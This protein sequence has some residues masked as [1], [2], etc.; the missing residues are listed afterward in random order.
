M[1]KKAS[2]KGGNFQD[3]LRRGITDKIIEALKNGCP[4]W[5][6][7]WATDPNCGLPCNIASKRRYSGI[8]PLILE[9]VALEKGYNAR[10]WGTYKQFSALEGQVRKGEKST[11]VVFYKVLEV[12][13]KAADGNP[14]K[15]KIFFLRTYNVFNL[16]Q[17]DG[18]KLDKYRVKEEPVD[19]PIS[20]SDCLLD[21]SAAEKLIAST[22]AT[23]KYGGNRAAY[24]IPTPKGMW[25]NHSD[26]DY[27]KMPKRSQFADP[28]EFYATSF[29]EL[30]HWSEVR[31]KWENTYEMNELIAEITACYLSAETNVPNRN[32]EN[33]N[34]YLAAWL[35]KMES[36]PKWIFHA[37]TQ[38]SKVTD[39]LLNFAN[40]NQKPGD[41]AEEHEPGDGVEEISEQAA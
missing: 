3:E 14:T 35:E 36:D 30:A 19:L 40:V 23:I 6:R 15:K 4:P 2:K 22:G 5:R 13:A 1:V 18:E 17:V 9:M 25:P 11:Q 33:H 31:L 38:A 7:P 41:E 37:S 28:A 32:L 24:A 34:R 21:Y 10:Y 12:D 16:D 27:I 26:G 29:H 8:N 39:F 20:A